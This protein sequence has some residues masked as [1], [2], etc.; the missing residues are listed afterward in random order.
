MAKPTQET[1]PQPADVDRREAEMTTLREAV[2]TLREAVATLQA[3][4]AAQQAKMAALKEAM[5]TLQ[6]TVASYSETRRT[7][8]VV[9]KAEFNEAAR[10]IEKTLLKI[11]EITEAFSTWADECAEIAKEISHTTNDGYLKLVDA[12]DVPNVAR[13]IITCAEEHLK[14]LHATIQ[15]VLQDPGTPLSLGLINKFHPDNWSPELWQN[16]QS[17]L[18]RLFLHK[19]MTVKKEVLMAQANKLGLI[20]KS[21]HLNGLEKWFGCLDKLRAS[22]VNKKD[23]IPIWRERFAGMGVSDGLY[24]TGFDVEIATGDTVAYRSPPTIKISG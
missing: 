14:R 7:S 5:A 19:V 13:D 24:A 1:E 11:K 16:L 15:D 8:E 22:E 21:V 10:T 3:K 18:I 12:S 20:Q 23:F 9:S 4:M 2:T 17:S 6:A